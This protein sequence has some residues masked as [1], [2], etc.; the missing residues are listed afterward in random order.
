MSELWNFST[1]VDGEEPPT[2]YKIRN[3]L[4]EMALYVWET[5]NYEEEGVS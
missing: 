2:L 4:G 5:F 1:F 3:N